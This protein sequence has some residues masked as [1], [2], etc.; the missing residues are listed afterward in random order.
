MDPKSILVE[1]PV[2][3]EAVLMFLPIWYMSASDR[4]QLRQT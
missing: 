4:S 1:L 3:E 2:E